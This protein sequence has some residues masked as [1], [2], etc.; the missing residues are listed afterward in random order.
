MGEH[1]SSGCSGSPPPPAHGDPRIPICL[2][3][4]GTAEAQEN[5][6]KG[7]ITRVRDPVQF[8]ALIL[9]TTT[10]A[11]LPLRERWEVPSRSAGPFG[12]PGPPSQQRRPT[13]CPFSRRARSGERMQPPGFRSSQGSSQTALRPGW[14][15]SSPP[16]PPAPRPATSSCASPTP[17]RS[18]CSALEE[19][20][21]GAVATGLVD[22]IKTAHQ[23]AIP[24]TCRGCVGEG[25]TGRRATHC[26][27]SSAA[28][29]SSLPVGG[30]KNSPGG[31]GEGAFPP[32]NS[33]LR[34]LLLSSAPIVGP[35]RPPPPPQTP[36]LW[37]VPEN[38]ASR[39][40]GTQSPADSWDWLA[41]ASRRLG[42]GGGGP[43]SCSPS[44]TC[45]GREGW[46]GGR[47]PSCA[48]WGWGGL[49]SQGERRG[50]KAS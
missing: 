24:W 11:P 50:E 48:G 16:Q 35:S 32:R 38:F 19:A 34:S 3:S 13:T 22:G 30:R 43:R 10:H 17:S 41:S 40:T 46:G 29:D 18:L 15:R 44:S 45:G 27:P 26:S 6:A 39:V 12:C 47:E 23:T 36:W 31:G 49:R 33:R 28:P 37:S 9:Q 25:R 4:L 1:L 20:L 7:R 8:R 21:G 5:L 42:V 14:T 2:R